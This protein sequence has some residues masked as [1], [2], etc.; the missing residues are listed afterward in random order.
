MSDIVDPNRPRTRREVLEDAEC[1]RGILGGRELRAT[2]T[3]PLPDIEE[4]TY[5][6]VLVREAPSDG[7]PILR[8]GLVIATF[9]MVFIAAILFFAPGFNALMAGVF[10]GFFA[11]RWGRAFVAAALASVA[12]PAFFA[13]LYGWDTPD[14]L[15]LFYGL[16]F[17]GWSL[18]NAV[19]MFIGAAAGVYSRPLADRGLHRDVMAG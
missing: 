18:L 9:T 4:T 15:Y 7:L 13:F 2:A 1:Q 16:G 10:G 19:C 5:R 3:E 12:V 11:R 17:G 6:E 8:R 14:M